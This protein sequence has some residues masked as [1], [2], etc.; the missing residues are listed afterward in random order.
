MSYLSI[1]PSLFFSLVLLSLLLATPSSTSKVVDVKVICTRSQDSSFCSKILNSK[2]GGANSADLISLVQY[3]IDV[4]RV[5]ATDT[6]NLIN[7][8]IAKSGSDQKAKDHYTK[9]WT[10]FNK[11][12]GALS[13]IDR[14][15]DL[16]KKEDYIG[17]NT[18]ASAII[19]NIN[20]YIVGEDPEDPPYTDKS[21]LPQFVDVVKKVADII[22]V[23]SKYLIKK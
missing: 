3:T 20:D 4:A 19:T 9:C 23:I 1:R 13:D 12:E 11:D 8:L 16:L 22:L 2:P 18:A 14:V 7:T 17:V 5:D 6:L 15:Q 21:N 10:H